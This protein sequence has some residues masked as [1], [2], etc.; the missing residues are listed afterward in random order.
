M[1]PNCRISDL[2]FK[3]VVNQCD[4]VRLGPVCDV[5]FCVATG[6]IVALVVPGPARLF[7]FFWHGEDII[8]PWRQIKVIGDDIILV[9]LDLGPYYGEGGRWARRPR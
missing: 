4:G 8:I 7:G 3:E 2:R 6:Q 9:D 1:G 5:E